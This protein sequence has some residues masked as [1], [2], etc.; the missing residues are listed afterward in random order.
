MMRLEYFFK[1]FEFCSQNLV[2]LFNLFRVS[3]IYLRTIIIIG[4]HDHY[5]EFLQSFINDFNLNKG[6]R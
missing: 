6:N 1:I 4:N 3:E 2:I 5:L